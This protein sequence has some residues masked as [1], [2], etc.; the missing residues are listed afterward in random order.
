M[1]CWLKC[2]SS[3]YP[4]RHTEQKAWNV[5]GMGKNTRQSNS[6]SSSGYRHVKL[7]IPRE[8]TQCKSFYRKVYWNGDLFPHHARHKGKKK[9]QRKSVQGGPEEGWGQ[10]SRNKG[11]GRKLLR[12]T[13]REMQT[14]TLMWS[15]GKQVHRKNALVSS[16]A[17]QQALLTLWSS[18]VCTCHRRLMW[19]LPLDILKPSGAQIPEMKR[20]ICIQP[21]LIFLYISSPRV[22]LK[23]Q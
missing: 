13:D 20:G 1:K 17:N 4:L 16:H 23:L 2:F 5:K 6:G 8:I 14:V 19:G 12:W 9:E 15:I 3:Y 7:L 11:K 21:M 18:V 10:A 22:L